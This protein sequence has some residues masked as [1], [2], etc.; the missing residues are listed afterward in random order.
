MNSNLLG[1]T[2]CFNPNVSPNH[3]VWFSYW[4][5]TLESKGRALTLGLLAID[6]IFTCSLKMLPSRP[7]PTVLPAS[8][9]SSYA[10]AGS[11]SASASRPSSLS[12]PSRLY[13]VVFAFTSSSTS[14]PL[15]PLIPLIL[16]IINTTL[17][18]CP[19]STFSCRSPWHPAHK[20][21]GYR[22]QTECV[23]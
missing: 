15:C 12:S 6:F 17:S 14:W 7:S 1:I 21:Q 8:L 23:F 9:Y 10:F 20:S 5:K 22:M 2:F 11:L 19:G 18:T 16:V 3:P 13:T 4:Y